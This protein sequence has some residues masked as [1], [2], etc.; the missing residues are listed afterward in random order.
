MTEIRFHPAAGDEVEEA[1][2][3]YGEHNPAAAARFAAE[4]GRALDVIREA[5]LQS[6]SGARN[7]RRFILRGFP[8]T[9]IY[10]V[11]QAAKAAVGPTRAASLRRSRTIV[12]IIAVAHHSRRPGYWFDR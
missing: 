12:T 6:P 10:R 4:V 9:I 7:T 2:K 3:F 1:Y 5:P 11:T 8:F